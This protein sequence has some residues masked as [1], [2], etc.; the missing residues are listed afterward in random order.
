[1]FFSNLNKPKGDYNTKHH[2][3]MILTNDFLSKI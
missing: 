2:I 1:M 3:K